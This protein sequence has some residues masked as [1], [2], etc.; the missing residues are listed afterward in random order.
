MNDQPP[1]T[2]P[3]SIHDL[4]ARVAAMR[5]AQRAYFREPTSERLA[6]ARELERQLDAVLAEILHPTPSLF[7]GVEAGAGADKRRKRE[8]TG[9]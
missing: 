2:A 5:R 1:P 9:Q 3:F 4:A 8:G 6:R 7:D